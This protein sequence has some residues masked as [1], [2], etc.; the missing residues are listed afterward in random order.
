MDSSAIKSKRDFP[1][2]EKIA[3]DSDVMTASRGLPRPYVIE[4]IRSTM[5]R[6]K[7]GLGTD[8]EEITYEALRN[9]V[10]AEIGAGSA[11]KIGR[12]INGTGI[13]IHTNLG[14]APLS[15]ALFSRIRNNINGYG[16]LELDV[17]SGKRSKRGELAEKY[18]AMVSGAELG[19]IVNNNAAALFVILNTFAVRRKVLI[20][21]GEL[22][23]I[24]GG[25]RIPD[26]IK[27]SGARLVE[28]GTTN[29][30]TL[31]D[32]KNALEENPALILKVH[33]S[34]FTV[35]GFAEEVNLKAL[36]D[37]GRKHNIPVIN[38]L[39]SGVLID[40]S[41]FAGAREPTVQSSVRDGADLTCFSGD[42]LLGGVQAGL[43]VG[44]EDFISRIK[45][46]PIYRT[47][48]V[49]KIVFSTVEELLG[50]YLDGTWKENIKLW[51]LASTKESELYE[52]GRTLLKE[53]D[54]G[55]K[56]VLE[57]SKAE[58][59]GGALPEVPLPSVA[60][61]FRSKLSAQKTAALFRGAQPPVIGHISNDK[62]MIDLKAVDEDDAEILVG[63]IRKVIDQ[64]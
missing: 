20:S 60:L 40:T 5:D 9:R 35:S 61:V 59:G 16:N 45:K 55:D 28:I 26:I 3:S 52:K 7:D 8:F 43:I 10:I 6:L 58:M 37:L 36:V 22:V 24:G 30:T 15:E 49:D 27:K 12:V 1:A 25:F 38:D 41:E 44:R 57:G 54:A 48:R 29:I 63:I 51:R 64:I 18:L 46:N 2:V 17:A 14:R 42:K 62:F 33:K 50:Y 34:N 19:T 11:G 39:G 31:D 47:V 4:I 56:I 23:Q 53:I 13:L 32:Y 21:R